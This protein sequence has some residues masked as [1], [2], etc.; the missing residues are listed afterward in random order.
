MRPSV[1]FFEVQDHPRGGGACRSPVAHRAQ[2]LA[3]TDVEGDAVDR[4]DV[5]SVRA[6]RMPLG[7]GEVLCTPSTRNSGSASRS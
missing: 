7:E 6:N 4:Y 5:T 1:G 2:R 3:G